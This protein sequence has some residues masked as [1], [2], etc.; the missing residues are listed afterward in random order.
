MR[1]WLS[2]PLDWPGATTDFDSQDEHNHQH[3]PRALD[4]V[5]DNSRRPRCPTL[6]FFSQRHRRVSSVD[7]LVWLTWLS[8]PWTIN[9]VDC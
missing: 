4:D 7:R 5:D 1:K 8:L 3:H 6:F 9:A 2:L